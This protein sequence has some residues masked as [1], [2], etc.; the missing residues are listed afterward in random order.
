MMIDARAAAFDPARVDLCLLERRLR[1]GRP[2]GRARDG[3]IVGG[4]DAEAAIRAA[5]NGVR[6]LRHAGT[7]AAMSLS[8]GAIISKGATSSRRS[9][10]TRRR[11]GPAGTVHCSI[12]DWAK[13]AA[14]A[15]GGRAW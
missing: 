3:R 8:P 13:F 2:D 5:G 6:G 7:D 15:P 14:P 9:T 1:A 10:T 12:P 11:L 4:A